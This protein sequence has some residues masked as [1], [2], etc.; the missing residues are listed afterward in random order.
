MKSLAFDQDKRTIHRRNTLKDNQ[1][2]SS[3]YLENIQGEILSARDKLKAKE[4]ALLNEAKGLLETKVSLLAKLSE[5]LAWLDVFSSQ[6]IFAKEKRFTKPEL[7][8]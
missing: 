2:Y 7:D 6:A 1:R 4:L 8:H 5:K 3:P